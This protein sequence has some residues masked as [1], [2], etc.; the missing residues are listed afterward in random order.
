LQYTYQMPLNRSSYHIKG[1]KG[2]IVTGYSGTLLLDPADSDV[3]TLRI[4]SDE[5]PENKAVC[6]A[7]SEIDYARV[8]I[9]DRSVLIPRETRL[10]II[11]PKGTETLSTTEYS[12]CREYAS[13]TRLLFEAP[14][15][16]PVGSAQNSTV[17]AQLPA[18]L[19]FAGRIVT[20]LDSETAAAGDPVEVVL[21]KP[22]RDANHVLIAAAGTLLHARLKRVEQWVAGYTQITLEFETMELNGTTVP[23]RARADVAPLARSR[24][25][26]VSYDPESLDTTSI[27]FRG[28]RLRFQQF[29]WGWTTLPLDPRDDKPL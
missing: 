17:T 12:K 9:H 22:M 21:Q 14:Q 24:S 15:D 26:L 29:D 5:L 18:G 1:D 13:K 23:L 19:H 2:W 6:Q 3:V 28:D 25:I 4:R 10:G 7:S 8:A 16:H 20:P 11:D 27:S